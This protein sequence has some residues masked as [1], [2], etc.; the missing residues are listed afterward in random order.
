MLDRAE[1]LSGRTRRR[2]VSASAGASVAYVFID[3][4]PELALQHAVVTKA[5]GEAGLPFAEQRVYVLAL[6]SFVLFYGLEHLVLKD[7]AHREVTGAAHDEA[8][9]FPAHVIAFGGYTA[10]IGDLLVERAQ[11]GPVPLAIYTLAM[12]VHFIIVAHA[13]LERFRRPYA[14]WG[15]WVLAASVVAGWALGSTAGI[16]DVTFARLFAVLAGG[17]VITACRANCWGG[18]S[19]RGVSGPSCSA[20]WSSPSRSWRPNERSCAWTS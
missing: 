3:V 4:L 20:R 17:V 14:Q 5:V 16:S 7:R 12:A 18:G 13:L 10:L 1:A 11:H 6:L 2:L 15:R 8:R 9:F 19:V